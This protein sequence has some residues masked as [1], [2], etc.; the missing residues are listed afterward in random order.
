[1]FSAY[2]NIEHT[3]V[4]FCIEGTPCFPVLQVSV[5]VCSPYLDSKLFVVLTMYT[6]TLHYIVIIGPKYL[7]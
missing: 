2:V 7:S 5:P 6:A 3:I 1:M 4:R